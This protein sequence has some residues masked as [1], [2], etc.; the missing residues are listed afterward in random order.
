MCVFQPI[1]YT[2]FILKL[3]F[4]LLLPWLA[5]AIIAF[6]QFNIFFVTMSRERER[7][8]ERDVWKSWRKRSALKINSV[9]QKKE[10]RNWNWK[11]WNTHTHT[12]LMTIYKSEC[13]ISIVCH[14]MSMVWYVCEKVWV[15]FYTWVWVSIYFLFVLW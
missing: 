12:I 9:K 1:I 4:S 7:K 5:I 2:I 6:V 10:E 3:H 14:H 15:C 13:D 8:S 11:R